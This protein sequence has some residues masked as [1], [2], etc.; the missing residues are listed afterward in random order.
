MS[1]ETTMSWAGSF[2]LLHIWPH[3]GSKDTTPSARTEPRYHE[4]GGTA[5]LWQANDMI[6]YS[7]G[8]K[9]PPQQDARSAMSAIEGTPGAATSVLHRRE[10]THFGHRGSL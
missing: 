8:N 7:G 1:S 6:I 10:L 2:F 3:C 5:P 4:I 9:E